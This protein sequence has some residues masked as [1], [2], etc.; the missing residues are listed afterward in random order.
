MYNHNKQ[1]Y[2]YRLPKQLLQA[3]SCS[4]CGKIQSISAKN[5]PAP[6]LDQVKQSVPAVYHSTW[7]LGKAYRVVQH[8]D[9]YYSKEYTKLK[10]RNGYTVA[11]QKPNSGEEYFG[12]IQY[13]LVVQP[14][15]DVSAIIKPFTTDLNHHKLCHLI[16]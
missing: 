14:L 13:F 7:S 10:K 2:V 8:G 3:N 11:Y 9:F 16:K 15:M 6:V 5:I 12:H 4:L 1:C